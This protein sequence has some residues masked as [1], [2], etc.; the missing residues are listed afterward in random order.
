MNLDFNLV[1]TIDNLFF[2]VTTTERNRKQLKTWVNSTFKSCELRNQM[3]GNPILYFAHDMIRKYS[4]ITIACRYSPGFYSLRNFRPGT[5]GMPLTFIYRPNSQ[6]TTNL[7]LFDGNGTNPF[8]NVLT[9]MKVIKAW[10]RFWQYFF[11]DHG[12]GIP[13]MYCMT[14]KVLM[15]VGNTFR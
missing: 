2:Y 1:K 12:L 14:S 11:R 8:G 13:K 4:N 7:T 6:V 10:E 5:S 3:K 9:I 15:G